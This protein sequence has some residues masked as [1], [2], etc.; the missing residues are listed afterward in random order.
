MKLEL[1]IYATGK[2]GYH[3]LGPAWVFFTIFYINPIV[4]DEFDSCN[5]QLPGY[6]YDNFN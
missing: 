6:N 2:L 4:F 1:Y 5:M 3:Q